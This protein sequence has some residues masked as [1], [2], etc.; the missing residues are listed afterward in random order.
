[1][2]STK[3]QKAIPSAHGTTTSI[4]ITTIHSVKG[5]TV[6]AMMLVS[7]PTKQGTTDGHWTQWIENSQ[8]EAAR[9]A[10]VASSRPRQLLAWAI[11]ESDAEQKAQLEHLG[12]VA[13]LET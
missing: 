9:L 10:Y 8:S 7:A 3:V 2:A 1:M 4:R 5:Q 12:F 11:P 13:A 6:E